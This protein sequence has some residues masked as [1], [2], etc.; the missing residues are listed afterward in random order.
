M[1]SMFFASYY[2]HPLHLALQDSLLRTAETP[3]RHYNDEKS[4]FSLFF[5]SPQMLKKNLPAEKSDPSQNRS[6]LEGK[7]WCPGR[8]YIMFE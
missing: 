7:Q 8:K 2:L 6:F 4:C 3:S 5:P 1:R